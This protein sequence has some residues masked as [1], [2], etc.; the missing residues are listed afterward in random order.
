MI[1]SG[2]GCPTGNACPR[3]LRPWPS[4][5]ILSVF[6][7]PFTCPWLNAQSTVQSDS[8]ISHGQASTIR[9]ELRAVWGGTHLR[10]YHGTVRVSN[11]RLRL[12]RNLSL[13]SDSIGKIHSSAPDTL[14]IRTPS[15]S[16]FGGMDI[17]L[18]A[19][20][21]SKITFSFQDPVNRKTVEHSVTIQEILQGNWLKEL[22]EFGAKLAVE[23]QV[24][25]RLQFRSPMESRVLD[26]GSSWPI[27]IRGSRTGL[28][29]GTYWLKTQ[30]SSREGPVVRLPDR[31]I[32]LDANGSFPLQEYEVSIPA[33][34]DSYLLEFGLHQRRFLDSLLASNALLTRRIEFVALDNLAKRPLISDW[35][36]QLS[37][38]ALEASRP[39][40]LS[41]LSPIRSPAVATSES[42]LRWNALA[43]SLKQPIRHGDMSSRS[44]STGLATDEDIQCLTLGTHA[45]LAIPIAGLEAGVPHRM[46]IRTPQDTPFDLVISVK[47]KNS[48]NEFRPL[49]SDHRIT[50]SDRDCNKDGAFSTHEVVFWSSGQSEYLF[51]ANR[52]RKHSAS[53]YDIQID[54]G[55]LAQAETSAQSTDWTE[56]RMV[57]VYLDKPLLAEFMASPRTRDSSTGR[58]L[59]SW[60]TWQAACERLVQYVRASEANLLVL[61]VQ[62]DGGAIFPSQHLAPTPRYDNGLFFSDGRSPEIKDAVE[63]LL[64]HCERSRIRVVL[65][66]ELDSALPELERKRN[67]SE[68]LYQQKLAEVSEVQLPP[69]RY[70]PLNKWVQSEILASIREIVQ[71]YGSSPAFAGIQLQLDRESQVIF[72]GD[73]WG[74]DRETLAEFERSSRTQLP[75][76]DLLPR[77]F[78]GALRLAF[79]D[80]RA[81]QL[82][83][84]FEEIGS[85]VVS[86]NPNNKLY[87]NA[88]RLWED[89]P[90]Q[91]DFY[92][93][94]SIMR[95]PNEYLGAFG[96]APNRLA[97][98]PN[99][100]L[101]QGEF[102]RTQDTFSADE[103]VRQVSRQH[104]LGVSQSESKAA[105]VVQQPTAYTLAKYSAFEEAI[106]ST[107]GRPTVYPLKSASAIEYRRELVEQIF[108]SDVQL[109]ANGAWLPRAAS[110]LGIR[111]LHRTLREFPQ[112]RFK[113]FPTRPA[114]SNVKLRVGKQ[115]ASTFLQVINNSPW[116]EEV[117]LT[118]QSS[119]A[120]PEIRDLRDPRKDNPTDTLEEPVRNVKPRLNR[121]RELTKEWTT[122]IRPFDVIGFEIRDPGFR[123]V[124]AQHQAPSAVLSRIGEQLS[125]IESVVVRAA[126]PTQQRP[127]TE[128]LGDFEQWTT[129]GKPAGWNVSSLPRVRISRSTDLPHSGNASLLIENE[130]AGDASAW[131]QSRP[132]RPPENG[133]IAVQAWLR[134]SAVDASSV[135]RM[136]VVGRRHS[137]QRFERSEQFGSRNRQQQ[138]SN[139]WGTRPAS[140]YV[141]E[142]PADLE[143]FFVSVELIG[144]G[145]V[146]VDDI[147][148]LE[149]WLEPQER[150]YLQGVMLVA[151]QKLTENNPFPAEQ[152]LSGPWGRYLAELQSNSQTKTTPA[153]VDRSVYTTAPK[154][155]IPDEDVSEKR[156]GWNDGPKVFQQLRDSMRE[157][158][159]R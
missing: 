49:S 101:M 104:G 9:C 28:S 12:V 3:R 133:R 36:P 128:L 55:L 114:K 88:T 39:G 61:K 110:S 105:I 48:E 135:V 56:Q 123:L 146:W 142:I 63:L 87:L 77:A 69:I 155:S 32:T 46:L 99:V 60:S 112:I 38:N 98:L 40:I 66:L 6:L 13:E 18:Q 120:N 30:V 64:R 21:S 78:Q 152:L 90:S 76:P 52:D 5:L 153:V 154:M 25:D 134:T 107:A 103:W 108:Q 97:S 35:I 29:P 94:D 80:W 27:A 144:K 10:R 83:Q 22:D 19:A 159:R 8:A 91:N 70:N 33:L 34:E 17:A 113:D 132:V 149:S 72:R 42:W 137:G 85:I 129:D 24:H 79:L 45:W 156:N 157:R 67:V 138:I 50:L 109:V 81:T 53:V 96:I 111:E 127:L 125:A 89:S 148:V 140:L 68:S 26:V 86:S 92:F 158:W 117:K 143:E 139:D 1:S 41:W 20:A 4:A 95:N 100:V 16:R 75:A 122:V 145:R 82:T 44:L 14:E 151:K 106:R 124:D 59:E 130:N 7:V 136:S 47:Q 93:A 37:V 15:P 147:Q 58:L 141:S 102:Q 11:G 43:D 51:L 23:R 131:I 150:V 62:A 54:K 2:Q 118:V 126:D 71:R 119:T 31:Q 84:F 73:R 57:G 121:S 65:A 74:F 116:E 115:N